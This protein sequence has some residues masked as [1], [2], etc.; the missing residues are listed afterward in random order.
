MNA[1][2]TRRHRTVATDIVALMIRS[3]SL[4][5]D[6]RAL[7]VVR[8]AVTQALADIEA[9]ALASRPAVEWIAVSERMPDEG[10]LV[11]LLTPDGRVLGYRVAGGQFFREGFSPYPLLK[12]EA[13]KCHW[14]PLPA[15]PTESRKL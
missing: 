7:R 9:A 3:S 12:E 2:V 6:A 11:A 8:E 13:S 4:A 15:P 14:M 1:A 5:F 10:S